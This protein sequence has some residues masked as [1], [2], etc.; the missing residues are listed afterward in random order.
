[1]QTLSKSIFKQMENV[2]CYERVFALR[3][4]GYTLA[5]HDE[6]RLEGNDYIKQAEEAEKAYP[7]WSER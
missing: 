3:N 1:M 5:K 4:Y 2:E 7:Y 6:T